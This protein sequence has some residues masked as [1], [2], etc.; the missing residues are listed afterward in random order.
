M[1][2]QKFMFY[3]WN[4]ETKNNDSRLRDN[5]PNCI[6]INE[7]LDRVQFVDN[8][9]SAVVLLSGIKQEMAKH[10]EQYH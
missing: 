7:T 3:G 4:I 8:E 5:C 6:W 2:N 10:L 9:Q 1:T